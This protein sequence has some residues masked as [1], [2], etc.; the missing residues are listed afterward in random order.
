MSKYR[1]FCF[2]VDSVNQLQDILKISVDKKLLKVCNRSLFSSI[3][4]EVLIQENE[5]KNTLNFNLKHLDCE[6]KNIYPD[7]ISLE[8]IEGL[9]SR[10]DI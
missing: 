6:L 5:L 7:D 3:D 4:K 10:K 1:F 2:R 9:K 8:Y